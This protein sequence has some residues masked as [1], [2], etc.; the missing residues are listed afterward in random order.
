MEDL[1]HRSDLATIVGGEI[2]PDASPQIRGLA[3]VD[4]RA[5][6]VAEDVDAGSS[7]EMVGE[8]ELVGL[9][10]AIDRREL[11]QVIEA[12]NAVA[13]GTLEQEEQQVRGGAHVGQG[14]VR[15]LVGERIVRRQRAELAVCDLGTHEPARQ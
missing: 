11:T 13:G 8:G 1:E 4:D 3:D 5:T 14:A 6:E 15:R 7:G 12:E 2:A 10:V 9:W